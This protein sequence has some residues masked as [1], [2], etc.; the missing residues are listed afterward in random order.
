MSEEAYLELFYIL[1]MQITAL[2]LR[3]L[4]GT[5]YH[6]QLTF[7]QFQAVLDRDFLNWID[8]WH[9]EYMQKDMTIDHVGIVRE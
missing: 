9:F 5:Y 6:I 2:L 1:I 4:Q 8:F 7:F 3:L